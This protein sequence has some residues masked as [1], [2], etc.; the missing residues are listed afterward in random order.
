M[1]LLAD[2]R[3]LHSPINYRQARSLAA[4][5][6]K[7]L[8]DMGRDMTIECARDVEGSVENTGFWEGGAPIDLSK[9]NLILFRMKSHLAAA[10]SALLTKRIPVIIIGEERTSDRLLQI[11][12]DNSNVPLSGLKASLE[13][14]VELLECFVKLRW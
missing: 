14:R 11:M 12:A 10:Y 6:Q 7:V 3:V 9:S 13:S 2:A 4:C 5:A 8:D 1:E